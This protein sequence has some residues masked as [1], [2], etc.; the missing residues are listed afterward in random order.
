MLL[1]E[2]LSQMIFLVLWMWT[3]VSKD[4]DRDFFFYVMLVYF[5]H[6]SNFGVLNTVIC[7]IP[8]KTGLIFKMLPVKCSKWIQTICKW[9]V[10]RK[11]KRTNDVSAVYALILTTLI[12]CESSPFSG[13]PVA[14]LATVNNCFARSRTSLT[15]SLASSNS[16]WK[17]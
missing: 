1:I 3:H 8:E 13:V 14:F 9:N 16:L 11:N 5:L 15:R 6:V 17:E 12:S 4:R 10:Q 2:I 7:M